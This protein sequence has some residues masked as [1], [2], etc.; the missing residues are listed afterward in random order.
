[1]RLLAVLGVSAL[2]LIACGDDG[3]TTSPPSTTATTVEDGGGC[4]VDLGATTDGATTTVDVALSEYA[5]DAAPASVPA[6]TVEFSATNDGMIAHELVVVRWDGDPADIPLNPVGGA[7]RQVLGDAIRGRIRLFP[8]GETCAGTV[9]LE[10][11][12]YALICNAVD[13]GTSPHFSQGMHTSFT[14]T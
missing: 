12:R 10:P 3:D 4:E 7:D 2:L 1:M 9:D 6:G 13:D 14:V 8:S 5:V 11:G